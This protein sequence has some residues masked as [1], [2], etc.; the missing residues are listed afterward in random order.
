MIWAMG[1]EI[2]S[3]V[4]KSIQ[5][6]CALSEGSWRSLTMGPRETQNDLIRLYIRLDGVTEL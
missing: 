2:A 4:K 1:P 3:V 5:E 6:N